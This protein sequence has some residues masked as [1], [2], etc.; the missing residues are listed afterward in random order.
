VS[1][2]RA[3]GAGAELVFGLH[4][5]RHALRAAP[6]CARE[7]LLQADRE[8]NAALREILADVARIG[9]PV[10]RVSRHELDVE[11][12]H[13]RHQ[14]VALRR[15]PAEGPVKDIEDLLPALDRDALL[16]VLDGVQDPHNLGACIRTADAAGVQAVIIPRDRAAPVTEAARKAASG[17]AEHLPVLTVTN[18][19]PAQ[20]QLKDAGVW[21]IGTAATA[22][23]SIFATDLDRPLALVLGGEG[24]GMRQNVAAQCDAVVGIPLAGHVESLNVSVAAGIC[25]FEVRRQ[26]S[27]SREK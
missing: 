24:G 23:A 13:G 14:G 26:R 15:T 19:A 7:L 12:T 4:A 11:T 8:P 17:A 10:R 16:L 5:V 3:A 2:A 27:P 21:I 1:A 9:I 18:I 22:E 6:Q 25:L 20:R